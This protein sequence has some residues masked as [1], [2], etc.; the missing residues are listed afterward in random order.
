MALYT[1]C[2]H[3]ISSDMMPCRYLPF[4]LRS[5][6]RNREPDLSFHFTA[7]LLEMD[8]AEK[9]ASLPD[10][11]IW[12]EAD[13]NESNRW[14]YELHNGTGV[15]AVDGDYSNATIHYRN[16][17]EYLNDENLREVFGQFIQIIVECKLIY[18]GFI[19]LHAACVEKDGSAF[20]FTGPS[21][22]GKSTRAEKWCELLSA[23]MIS[24]DRPSIDVAKKT[25]YGVPWD[26]KEKIYRNV[27]FPLAALLVVKRSEKVKVN[28]LME[29]EAIQ[30]LSGQISVPMW[31]TMLAAKA[32]YS[33]KKLI[34]HIP[35][36]E[37]HSEIDSQ[38]ILQSYEII[39]KNI[40]K[41]RGTESEKKIKL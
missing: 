7:E 28:E 18:D 40:C 25:V 21:G 41:K 10:M 1:V 34:K 37:V 36:Y 11:T 16:G 22:I 24:G 29:N 9:I 30:I 32:L 12:K 38:S 39:E 33:L 4:L 13:N 19:I 31:D 2:S 6:E 15:I 20:A 35:V 27:H 23:E 26:G 8:N 17:I 14:I 3:L 5:E